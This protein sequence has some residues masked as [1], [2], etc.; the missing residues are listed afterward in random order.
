MKKIYRKVT[1]K[2]FKVSAIYIIVSCLIFISCNRYDELQKVDQTEIKK[3]SSIKVND[4]IDQISEIL[5]GLQI[6]DSSDIAYGVDLKI[7]RA[8][9]LSLTS[10]NVTYLA[11]KGRGPGE[12]FQPS[13]IILRNKDELYIYD[14]ALDKIAKYKNEKIEKK[15]AAYADHNVWSRNFYGY[16]INEKLLTAIED[17]ATVRNMDFK[18]AKPLAFVDFKNN[19]IQK[20]GSFSPTIDK[21]DPDEKYPV[22]YHPSNSNKVYYV[23]KT[24][25][26]VLEY[27]IDQDKTSVLSSYQPSDFR[28]RSRKSVRSTSGD[29]EAAKSL[30]LDRSIVIGVNKVND[31]LFVVWQNLKDSFYENRGDFSSKNVDYFGVLYDLPDLKNP[32]EFSLPGRF[33][34]VYKNKLLVEENFGAQNIEVGFYEFIKEAN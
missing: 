33:F 9:K 13:Q 7:G 11:S 5:G 6:S 16:Y 15:F 27:D 34:G 26:S 8:Y 25:Y 17:P 32:R 12:L 22:I 1:E 19:S 18:N 28:V 31:Q 24:D 21:L 2:T 20:K 14:H 30:G 10:G 3:I 29:I 4:S 23:F